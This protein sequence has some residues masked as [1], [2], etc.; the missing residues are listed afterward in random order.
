MEGGGDGWGVVVG[1]EVDKCMMGVLEWK[2]WVVEFVGCEE[3]MRV[4]DL[5]IVGVDG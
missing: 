2:K 1:E 4:D 5:V 3:I